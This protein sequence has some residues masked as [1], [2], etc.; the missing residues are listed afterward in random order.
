MARYDC[1]N[2]KN[3]NF[4]NLLNCI[5][6]ISL[7]DLYDMDDVNHILSMH[8]FH[9]LLIYI[10]IVLYNKFFSRSN[11]VFL[12]AV[13]FLD[14]LSHSPTINCYERNLKIYIGQTKKT[15]LLLLF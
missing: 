13:P 8:F 6:S 3:T 10:K 12:I 14:V 5:Q 4:I 9:S 7:F 1:S 15:M 11:L 2:F